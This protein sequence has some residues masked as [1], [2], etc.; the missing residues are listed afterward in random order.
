MLTSVGKPSAAFHSIARFHFNKAKGENPCKKFVKSERKGHAT[1]RQR[2]YLFKF[3][4][5]LLN[6]LFNKLHV[7]KS[8]WSRESFFRNDGSL[9]SHKIEFHP[10]KYFLLVY[11]VTFLYERP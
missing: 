11:L 10:Q 4:D 7:V 3:G 2:D 6:K 1:L 5:L 8:R 9:S